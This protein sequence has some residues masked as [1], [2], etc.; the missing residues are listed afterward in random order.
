MSTDATLS[1]STSLPS[2]PDQD[3]PPPPPLPNDPAVLQMMI[4]ELLTT[5]QAR[6]RELEGVRHRL[7]LLLRRVYGPRAERYDPNQPLLFEVSEAVP[8]AEPEPAQEPEATETVV[9]VKKTKGRKPLPENLPRERREYD[10]TEEAKRCPCCGE[11]RVRIG[12][13]ESEQLDYLP[14]KMVVIEHVRWKYACRNC[15]EHVAVAAK[16]PQAI[17]KGLPGPGLLAHVVTSKYSDHLP[18]YRQEH[19]LARL[20]VE[21]SRSTSCGWM[22]ACAELLRPLYERMVALTLQSRVLHTDDTPVAVLDPPHDHTKTARFWIYLGDREHPYNVF[23]FTPTRQRI[24]PASFLKNYRGYLQADAFAGYDGIYATQDVTEVCCNAHARRKFFEAKET[25]AARSHQALAYYRQLYD[26]ERLA[27]NLS[28]DERCAFRQERAVPILNAF[29]AWLD[30]Q[31]SQVLPKSPIGQAIAYARNHRSALVRYTEAGF[32][33]IDNNAAER[34]MKRIAVGR[35]N[36]L[37]CGSDAGGE[38]A[39]ILFSF[40]STCARHKIDPF[41]YLRDV[42]TRLPQ[43]PP[44]QF[45]DFLPDRWLVGLTMALSKLDSG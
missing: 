38:T 34:E 25:D 31:E 7:D 42:F 40:T 29:R 23:D 20:G 1:T 28:D 27:K 22:K 14:S 4:H 11:W 17:E 30:E 15:Q 9:V 2:L 16:P 35:K 41:A 21:I 45:D 12:C 24:G 8:V 3:Q 13:E 6:D 18:L 37:F 19:M 39:S 10:L 43:T 5:L 44:E 32:L 26:L 33:A 36:W